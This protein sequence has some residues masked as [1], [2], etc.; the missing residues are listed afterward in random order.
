MSFSLLGLITENV[1]ISDKYCV[2]KTFPSFFRQIEK[3][4]DLKHNFRAAKMAIN[5]KSE[6]NF[7]YCNKIIVIGMRAAGKTTLSKY[8]A[9][10]LNSNFFDIDAQMEK[11][12]NLSLNKFIRKNGWA[13]FRK[14]EIETFSAIL[15]KK[16]NTIISCGGG[17]VETALFSKMVKNCCVVF[18]VRDIEKIKETLFQKEK[19]KRISLP[20]CDFLFLKKFNFFQMI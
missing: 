20:N 5:K 19:N 11:V 1:I 9:E 7:E 3:T 12:L 10:K 14:M 13:K 18:V 8:A 2:E 4:F 15:E 17:I 16:G 6:F